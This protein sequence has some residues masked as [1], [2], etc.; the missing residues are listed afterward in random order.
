MLRREPAGVRDKETEISG[1]SLHQKKGVVLHET[2]L[3]HIIKVC[4]EDASDSFRKNIRALRAFVPPIAFLFSKTCQAFLGALA[5]LPNFAS[6]F[7]FF[8]FPRK[9]AMSG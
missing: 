6:F 8:L 9:E 1:P 4:R 7:F 2:T 5:E 3:R